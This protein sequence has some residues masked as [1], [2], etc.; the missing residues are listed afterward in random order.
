MIKSVE[1]PEEI[2]KDII[3]ALNRGSTIELKKV[4]GDRIQILEVRK[5]LKITVSAIG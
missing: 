5:Q 4:N 1:L 3:K 2:E